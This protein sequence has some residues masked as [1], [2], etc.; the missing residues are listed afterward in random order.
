MGFHDLK[1]YLQSDNESK[2][3]NTLK[4]WYLNLKDKEK[5]K[6]KIISDIDIFINEFYKLKVITFHSFCNNITKSMDC[7]YF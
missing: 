6:E 1:L 7:N 3:D 5:S 4:D 2:I